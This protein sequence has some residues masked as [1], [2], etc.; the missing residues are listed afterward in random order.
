MRLRDLVRAEEPLCRECLRKGLVA[1]TEHIDHIVDRKMRPE[2]S[3]ERTNLQ[4]LCKACHNA[5][6]SLTKAS[7]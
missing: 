7:R 6:R 3:Y 5:K 4:G 2:L 1:S